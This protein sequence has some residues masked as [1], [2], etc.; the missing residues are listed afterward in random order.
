MVRYSAKKKHSIDLRLPPIHPS[1]PVQVR[2]SNEGFA[3]EPVAVGDTSAYIG[4]LENKTS[5]SDRNA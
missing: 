5:A 3:M 1:P 4:M 2:M